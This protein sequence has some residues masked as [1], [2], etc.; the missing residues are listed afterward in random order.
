MYNGVGWKG[1]DGTGRVRCHRTIEHLFFTIF[2]H[3]LTHSL[4]IPLCV[5]TWLSLSL[6]ARGDAKLEGGKCARPEA[7]SRL[8]RSHHPDLHLIDTLSASTDFPLPSPPSALFHPLGP[9]SHP[10]SFQHV[11]SLRRS[12][13][14]SS[15]GHPAGLQGLCQLQLQTVYV[16]PSPV[17]YSTSPSCSVTDLLSLVLSAVGCPIRLCPPHQP[18]VRRRPCRVVP[19]AAVVV[20]SSSVRARGA[21]AGQCCQ[22]DI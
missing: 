10:S 2:T 19:G 14:S 6:S 13:H 8:L 15:S 21:Q 22:Q 17:L 4:T 1:V 11:C 16:L 3:S 7:R 5:S 20:R 9:T 18:E 12:A